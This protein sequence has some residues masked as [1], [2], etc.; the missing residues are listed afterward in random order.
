LPGWMLMT[1]SALSDDSASRNDARLTPIAPPGPVAT[2][3]HRPGRNLFGDQFADG[4]QRHFGYGAG[5]RIHGFPDEPGQCAA[6][7]KAIRGVRQ[8]V[9]HGG[10]AIF[11]DA[12][13]RCE[14]HLTVQT[15]KTATPVKPRPGSRKTQLACPVLCRIAEITP[16]RSGDLP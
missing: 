16:R 13:S 10:S 11:T 15:S 6:S 14:K 7:C 1:P 4:L 8:V 12:P 3:T 9:P 2:A 5:D